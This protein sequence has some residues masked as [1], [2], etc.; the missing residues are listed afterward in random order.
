MESS[1]KPSSKRDTFTKAEKNREN[2]TALK[3]EYEN[4]LRQ[5]VFLNELVTL[6]FSSMSIDD[7]L[8]R[9]VIGIHRMLNID[10]VAIMNVNGEENIIECI[11][12]IGLEKE[13]Q[14]SFRIALD[15]CA[16]ILVNAAV[17][18]RPFFSHDEAV[19]I[20]QLIYA[21]LSEQEIDSLVF[22]LFSYRGTGCLQNRNDGLIMNSKY[23]ET[24]KHT[25]SRETSSIGKECIQCT[26]FPLFGIIWMDN[27]YSGRKYNQ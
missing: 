13:Q 8:N 25:S 22:P 20:K 26:H 16:P 19:A 5:F 21:S 10:R 17:S 18:K 3:D 4:L 7:V 27:R 15:S 2:I 24:R 1:V 14:E 11:H 23:E 6:L 12:G 9:I